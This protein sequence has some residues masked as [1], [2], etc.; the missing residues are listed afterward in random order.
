VSTRAAQAKTAAAAG[1]APRPL[2]TL[3]PE[4]IPFFTGGRHGELLVYRCGDCRYWLH[5]PAPRCPECLSANVG[6]ELASGHGTVAS[7]TVNWHPWHPA[8]PP[9]YVIAL[10]ELDE[11]PG[12]RLTTN[13]VNCPVGDVQVGIPVAVAFEQTGDIYLPVFTP[14]GGRQ[15]DGQ[16]AG[17]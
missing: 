1:V 2:P 13:L 4:T 16:E 17:R 9:P 7:F 11:Q 6:P 3:T 10:V 5:P 12:L 15:S 8:F 14:E